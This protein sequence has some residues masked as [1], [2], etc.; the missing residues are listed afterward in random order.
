MD[1]AGHLVKN[2]LAGMW[3]EAELAFPGGT[4]EATKS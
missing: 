1:V 3:K 2:E 4:D